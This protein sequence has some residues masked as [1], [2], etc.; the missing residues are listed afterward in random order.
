MTNLKNGS[1]VSYEDPK[2]L[3]IFEN[4]NPIDAYK[5][6]KESSGRIKI[7]RS[8]INSVINPLVGNEFESISELEKNIKERSAD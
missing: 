8:F 4:L 1:F 7:T 3:L 6:I 2:I 5:W